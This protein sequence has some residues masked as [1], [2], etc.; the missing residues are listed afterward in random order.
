VAPIAAVL[1]RFTTSTETEKHPSIKPQGYCLLA[2]IVNTFFAV[3]SGK[4]IQHVQLLA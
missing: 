2:I 1:F 4:N 3:I